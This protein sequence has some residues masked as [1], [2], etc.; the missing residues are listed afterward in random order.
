M[1]YE[2]VEID[3]GELEDCPFCGKDTTMRSIDFLNRRDGD[4]NWDIGCRDWKCPGQ[5]FSFF[6]MTKEAAIARY[7]RRANNG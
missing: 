5:D 6:H 4:E 1:D 2:D 7:N 3:E